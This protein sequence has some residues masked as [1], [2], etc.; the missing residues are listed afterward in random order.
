MFVTWIR[1][2]C[3]FLYFISFFPLKSVDINFADSA[4]CIPHTSVLKLVNELKI[5]GM[6]ND[7]STMDNSPVP[8]VS[9]SRRF[10]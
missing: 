2:V 3:P 8:N 1:M 7:I 9:A 4:S 6:V 10:H 5:E